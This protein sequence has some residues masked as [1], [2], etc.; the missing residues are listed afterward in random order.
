MKIIG[1]IPARYASTRLSGKPL[2]KLGG[3]TIIE[4]VYLN[5]LKSKY[6][7]SIYVA[8][9]DERIFNAVEKFG[10]NAIMTSIRHKSGTERIIEASKNINCE[11][12]VNIQGDEPFINPKTIDKIINC[13]IQEKKINIA[14]AAT[15]I[16]SDKD[17]NDPNTVKVVFDKNNNALYFSRAQI[18]YYRNSSS[19]KI[20]Y[21]HIGLYGYRKSFLLNYNKLEESNLERM[22]SLEQL[23]FLENGEK[24]KVI[25]TKSDSLSIDTIEDYKKAKSI[26]KGLKK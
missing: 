21:K 3:K 26:I 22:E 2:L 11:I 1:I 23:K 4:L 12:I 8:T 17:I 16:I 9:D 7:D 24:I 14:T 18:P 20:Y 19:K 13:L 15:R 5:S 25:I 6:L 10:G